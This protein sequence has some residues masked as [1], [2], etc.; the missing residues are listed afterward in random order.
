[1][2]DAVYSDLF[3][4]DLILHYTA[5]DSG[6]LFTDTGATTP[7]SDGNTVKAW[8]AQADAATNSA[9]TESTN[10]PTYAADYASSG[11][12][13]LVFDGTND[14]L[15]LTS[16]GIT[17]NARMFVLMAYTWIG[18]T[19]NTAWCRGNG[20]SWCRGYVGTGYTALQDS[21]AGIFGVTSGVPSARRVTA[22]VAGA[23]QTQVDT[24]GFSAGNRNNHMPA[25]ASAVFTLAALNT[26]S[27]SQFGNFALHEVLVIGHSCEWGQVL[28]GSKLLRDSWGITDPNGVPQAA[29]GGTSGFTGI[30]GVGALDA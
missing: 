25:G 1:M 10:G 27:L 4:S 19:T 5:A 18:A 6:S 20:A 12:P 7:A 30:R 8:T 26:G 28:R 3:G 16:T 29:A 23:D 13:A 11:Y 22:W 21:S 9:L 2:A 24:L 17:T 14:I 15:S